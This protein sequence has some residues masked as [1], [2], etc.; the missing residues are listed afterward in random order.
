MTRIVT[1]HQPNY[2]PWNGFFSKVRQSHCLII[3]DTYLLGGQSTFNRNKVRTFDGWRYLT[4]PIGHKFEGTRICDITSPPETEW[5]RAHWRTICDNYRKA[6]FFPAHRDFFENIYRSNF[7]FIWRLNEKIII[8]LLKCF[9]IEVEII[10]ASDITLDK[11][12]EKT[13]YMIALLKAVKADV[14]LSGPSGKNYLELEK[15][16][17][18]GIQLKFFNFQHPVYPQRYPG[19]ER[20]MSAIDLLFNAGPQSGGII[21]DSGSMEDAEIE[22]AGR[23]LV[24]V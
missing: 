10:K 17:Q 6:R 1:I 22:F 14:Y 16:P 8:Y 4:I 19:F 2:L 24:N 9:D 3:G 7:D 21:R 11:H 12:L 23:E 13:D 18:A 5:R 20:N 15:F